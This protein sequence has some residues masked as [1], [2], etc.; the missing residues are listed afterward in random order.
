MTCEGE[1]KEKLKFI[2]SLFNFHRD[3]GGGITC[4]EFGLLVSTASTAVLKA[5]MSSHPS[6]SNGSPSSN[7]E[8]ELQ[9]ENSRVDK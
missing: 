3:A 4:D 9:L 2:H 7:S 6:S 5:F 1:P 8:A